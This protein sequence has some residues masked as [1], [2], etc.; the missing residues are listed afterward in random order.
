MERLSNTEFMHWISE[1]KS[2]RSLPEGLLEDDQANLELASKILQYR[3]KSSMEIFGTARLKSELGAIMEALYKLRPMEKKTIYCLLGCGYPLE[4][5]ARL[6]YR[7]ELH[8]INLLRSGL[9][10]MRKMLD[11]GRLHRR[12]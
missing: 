10:T 4:V 3:N 12:G 5:V 7:S 6:T 11:Q 9:S 1:L 2:K 8:S